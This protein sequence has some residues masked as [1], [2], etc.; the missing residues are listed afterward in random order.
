MR[1]LFIALHDHC[2][3]SPQAARR[4]K[5]IAFRMWSWCPK[6]WERETGQWYHRN[7]WQ[8]FY[9]KYVYPGKGNHKAC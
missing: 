7:G 8:W 4:V 9:T 1:E 5:A 3:L 2:S 6:Y